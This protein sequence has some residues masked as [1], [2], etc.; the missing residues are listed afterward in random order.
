MELLLEGCEG[1]TTPWTCCIFRKNR[2]FTENGDPLIISAT[3]PLVGEANGS[4]VLP[5]EGDMAPLAIGGE[6]VITN[7]CCFCCC[8]SCLADGLFGGEMLSCSG[9][10]GYTV[11][12]PAPLPKDGTAANEAS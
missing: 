5:Y 9:I 7:F 6:D 11:L 1:K 2:A 8:A 10:G 4:T 12:P 3:E